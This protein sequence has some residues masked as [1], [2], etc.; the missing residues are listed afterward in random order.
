MFGWVNGEY[1][2]E[3]FTLYAPKQL[4]QASSVHNVARGLGVCSVYCV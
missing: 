4:L 3:T 2:L 1:S